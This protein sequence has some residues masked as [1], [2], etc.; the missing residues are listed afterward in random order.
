MLLLKDLMDAVENT[1]KTQYPGEPVYV[2]ALPKDF[3]RPSFAL[4]CQKNETAA[5]NPFLVQRTVTVLLTCFVEVNAYGDSSREA[6]NSRMDTLCAH[7]AQGYLQ[8]GDR[9]IH[10][11]ADRGTGAPDFAEVTLTFT[12]VDGRPEYQD[13]NAPDSGIPRMEDF[14][15]NGAVLAGGAPEKGDGE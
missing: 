11:Q 9:A 1:V 8:A 4:E 12:W 3:K 15:V 2:D 13:P 5:L 7:F 6:L 10:L 14:A